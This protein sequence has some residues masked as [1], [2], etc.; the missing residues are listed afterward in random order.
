MNI[1]RQNPLLATDVYKMGHM[2]QYCPGTSKVYSYLIARSD[3]TFDKTVFFGLQYYLKEYLSVKLT[4]E[5]GEE[6]LKYRK[7]I[8]GSNSVKVEQQF[9]DLC[10]LGY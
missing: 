10:N 3:K 5:M 1:S 6:F 4:P 9:R 8:L 7:T 2:E